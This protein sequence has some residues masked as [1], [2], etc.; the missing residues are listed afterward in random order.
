MTAPFATHHQ[1]LAP[2]HHSPRRRCV[3]L[4]RAVMFLRVVLCPIA[5]AYIIKG[6]VSLETPY[7]AKIPVAPLATVLVRAAGW[8]AAAA[9]AAAAAGA[10]R[11]R[12]PALLLSHRRHCCVAAAR[13]PARVL[14]V[15]EI[16]I[17]LVAK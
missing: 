5:A 11:A 15:Q 13:S 12:A 16:L 17:K 3:H 8:L 9:A 10:A 7:A 6:L 4:G 14:C 1:R 2:L